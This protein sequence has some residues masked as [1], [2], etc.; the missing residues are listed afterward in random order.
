MMRQ[1]MAAPFV[2]LP[3]DFSA[4][5]ACMATLVTLGEGLL[6]LQIFLD[7]VFELC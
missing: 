7:R 5:A 2:A 4:M 6:P 3:L 1:V